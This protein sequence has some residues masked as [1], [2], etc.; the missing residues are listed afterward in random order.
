LSQAASGSLPGQLE[1][2]AHGITA[3][4]ALAQQVGTGHGVEFA[5]VRHGGHQGLD[6]VAVP[7]I[8]ERL[9]EVG[10]DGIGNYACV[11]FCLR[12]SN[13]VLFVPF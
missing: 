13:L 10:G 11:H 6:I 1:A 7:G 3:D 9:Q 5:V 12:E 2:G 8:A 4:E